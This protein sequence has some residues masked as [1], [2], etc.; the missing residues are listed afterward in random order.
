M[1]EELHFVNIALLNIFNC[2]RAMPRRWVKLRAKQGYK[3]RA[4]PG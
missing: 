4:T 2:D 1:I 3:I